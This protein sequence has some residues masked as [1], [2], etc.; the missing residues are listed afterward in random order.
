MYVA[1]KLI[2]V[3][4]HKTGGTHIG[5]WLSELAPGE[6]VG[7]HNRVPTS[8]RDRFVIGSV[9]NPWDWYVSLWGYGCDGRG[10][11]YHAV[12]RG[13]SLRYL[14]RQLG[15]EMGAVG[16][17]ARAM[18]RQALADVQRPVARWRAVYRDSN[19]AEA[20]RDWLHLLMDN[21][22]RFD[23]AE[24]FG[25]SP[26]SRWG[27]LLTYRYLKLFTSLDARIY[28]D[29]ALGSLESAQIALSETRLVQ[30]VIR[31]ETLEDDL[32]EAVSRAGYSPSHDQRAAVLQ[33]RSAKTNTSSRR[34]ASFYYDAAT[35]ALVQERESLIITEH[36]YR[37]PTSGDA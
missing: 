11:V 14:L 19:N 15:S 36:G 29:P 1:E 13:L 28:N 9:R 30:H 7:K 8:L 32:L 10:A 17:P 6:Q 3:E 2:F 27:G 33:A 35:I 24:G 18:M 25:F 37:S 20:F 26:I 21:E 12:T 22:R 23:C 31:M 34:P 4:L 16:Y 5:K